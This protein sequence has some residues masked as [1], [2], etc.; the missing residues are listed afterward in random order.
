LGVIVVL[1]SLAVAVAAGPQRG[2]A[3]PI[4]SL[5]EVKQVVL[6][7]FQA[8]PDYQAGDLI[9]NEDVEPLLDKLQ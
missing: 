3:R 8:K 9:T 4:P 7:Y 1:L 2:R 5:S 6:R